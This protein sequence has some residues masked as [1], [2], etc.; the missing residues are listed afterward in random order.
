[1]IRRPPSSPL[2]PSTTLS[3]LPPSAPAVMLI[4]AM[5]VALNIYLYIRVPKGFFPQQDTGLMGGQIQA[6]QAISFQAMREKLRYFVDV[7]L[8]DPAVSTVVGFTGG[9]KRNGANMFISLKPRAQRQMTA[10][11]VIARLR[12][13]LGHEP[14]ANLYLQPWQDIRVGCRSSR[15][16]YQYTLQADTITDPRAWEPRVRVMKIRK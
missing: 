13:K 15:A 7:V 9:G 10:D 1:M 16:Q 8:H 6:D 4:L 5:T 11:A 2:F 14:G 12:G 3:R